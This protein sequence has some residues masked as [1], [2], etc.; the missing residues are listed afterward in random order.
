MKKIGVIIGI[1]IIIVVGIFAFHFP[2]SVKQSTVNVQSTTVSPKAQNVTVTYKGNNGV[3]A[4]TLLKKQATVGQ[5]H[6]GLVVSINGVKPTGHE[7][8]AFFINGKLAP[9]GPAAYQ[10]KNGDTIM[11]KI[12]KY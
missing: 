9:V 12:E 11:W 6:S 2:S 4:L 3:D 7:Y 10:T 5:D 1:I 8:W